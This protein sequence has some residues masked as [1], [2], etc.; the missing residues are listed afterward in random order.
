MIQHNKPFSLSRRIAVWSAFALVV[1][2]GIATAE[3]KNE[4]GKGKGQGKDD[5]Q[6]PE[7]FPTTHYYFKADSGCANWPDYDF[8]CE[9]QYPSWYLMTQTPP[10]ASTPKFEYIE[11]NPLLLRPLVWEKPAAESAELSGDN[12][13]VIVFADAP[14]SLLWPDSDIWVSLRAGNAHDRKELVYVPGTGTVT[15]LGVINGQFATKFTNVTTEPYSE[16]PSSL[17]VY[18]TGFDILNPG[19]FDIRFDSVDSPSCVVING[20]DCPV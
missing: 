4:T 5:P 20:S 8:F 11:K 15:P 10:N 9:Q 6:S 16:E 18:I 14:Q 19:P 2:A 3:A 7:P 13:T 12:V 1:F 17:S